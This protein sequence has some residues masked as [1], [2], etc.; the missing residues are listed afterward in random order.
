MPDV[1]IFGEMRTGHSFPRGDYHLV[2]RAAV[3]KVWVKL[4]AKLARPA[5]ARIKSFYDGWINVFHEEAP[6]EG[7]VFGLVAPGPLDLQSN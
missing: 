6:R 2:E 1:A 4:P 5:G 7:N 3:R